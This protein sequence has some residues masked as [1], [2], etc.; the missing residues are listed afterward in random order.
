TAGLA[1]TVE[2]RTS[3][4]ALIAIQGPLAATIL[5]RLTDTDLSEL[6]YYAGYPAQVT[7]RPVLLARTGYTG[8]DGFEIFTDPQDAPLLWSALAEAGQA[9]GLIPAGL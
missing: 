8:E 1:A 2:D 3:D 6:R 5:S 4:Y 9:D 7:G